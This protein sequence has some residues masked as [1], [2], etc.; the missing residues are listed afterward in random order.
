VTYDSE[1][2]ALMHL[3]QNR[4]DGFIGVRLSQEI[5]DI[6]SIVGKE[7]GAV[8]TDMEGGLSMKTSRSC[9]VSS[10]KLVPKLIC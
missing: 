4:L 9:I 5:V 1:L 3:A 7:I 2:L 8:C 6:A 10:G